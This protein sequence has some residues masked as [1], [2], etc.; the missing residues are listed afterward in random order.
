MVSEALKGWGERARRAFDE[1]IKVGYRHFD[2]ASMYWTESFLGDAMAAAP[3]VPIAPVAP[4]P[5]GLLRV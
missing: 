3:V 1:A 4:K 2:V 5:G